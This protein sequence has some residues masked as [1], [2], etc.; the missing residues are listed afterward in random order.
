MGVEGGVA[1]GGRATGQPIRRWLADVTLPKVALV[2]VM[3][4]YRFFKKKTILY[5]GFIQSEPLE[6]KTL[7]LKREPFLFHKGHSKQLNHDLV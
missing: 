3:R 5:L 6:K 7:L 4:F 2:P 1:G